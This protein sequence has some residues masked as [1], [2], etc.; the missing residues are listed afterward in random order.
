MAILHESDK[1]TALKEAV[2]RAI[3]IYELSK[4]EEQPQWHPV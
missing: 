3:I 1:N 4:T 2:D